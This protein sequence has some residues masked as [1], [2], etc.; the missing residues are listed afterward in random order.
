[1]D[2]DIAVNKRLNNE[3]SGL[4]KELRGL[5]SEDC[6]I[7]EFFDTHDVRKPANIYV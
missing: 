2:L 3:K 7:P 4:A 5:N 1:M 6:V